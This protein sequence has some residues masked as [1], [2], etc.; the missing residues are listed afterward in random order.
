MNRERRFR[1]RNYENMQTQHKRS[2]SSSIT[3]IWKGGRI[4]TQRISIIIS[5]GEENQY[6]II[7]SLNERLLLLANYLRSTIKIIINYIRAE[8]I[9]H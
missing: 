3:P 9:Q 1:F 4:T 7:L 8:S 5:E 6:Y 2:P